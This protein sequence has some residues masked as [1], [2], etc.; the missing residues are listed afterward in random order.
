MM[1]DN[2]DNSL[3]SRYWGFVPEKNIVGK[4]LLVWMNFS[5]L[6]RIGSF[7]QRAATATMQRRSNATRYH[8]FGLL[9]VGIV[10]ALSG[11][12][13]AQVFPTA[14]EYRAFQQGCHQA[15]PVATRREFQ[16]SEVRDL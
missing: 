3:D 8:H 4:G 7:D 6:K 9:F 14:A 2:R 13:A 16:K 1:G 5:V 15:Q 10:I 12:V 11:V